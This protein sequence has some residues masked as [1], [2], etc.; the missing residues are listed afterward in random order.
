MTP[1][2]SFIL[3]LLPH[4][5]MRGGMPMRMHFLRGSERMRDPT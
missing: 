3:S 5:R 4:M 1:T 2:T